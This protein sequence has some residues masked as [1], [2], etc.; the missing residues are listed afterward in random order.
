MRKRD[1]K[2]AIIAV[3][4]RLCLIIFAMLRHPT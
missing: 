2:I 4:H 3:A 1:Y